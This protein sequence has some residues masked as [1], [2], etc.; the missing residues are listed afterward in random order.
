MDCLHILYYKW[1]C[2]NSHLA[3][4]PFN[5]QNVPHLALG[6]PLSAGLIFAPVSF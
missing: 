2:K 3:I 1:K 4:I 5:A 6:D